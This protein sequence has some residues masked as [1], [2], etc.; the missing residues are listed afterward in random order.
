VIGASITQTAPRV[1]LGKCSDERYPARL[2][3]IL[4]QDTSE[5]PQ[6]GPHHG[7]CAAAC[8]SYIAHQREFIIFAMVMAAELEPRTAATSSHSGRRIA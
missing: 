7:P 3:V 2:W 4:I 5:C 6:H 8:V 1:P